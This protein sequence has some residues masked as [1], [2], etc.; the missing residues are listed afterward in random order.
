M[1]LDKE[2]LEEID[3]ICQSLFWIRKKFRV[4]K[5]QK[6]IWL[7]NILLNFP[8]SITVENA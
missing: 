4:S 7:Y 6:S 5:T 8:T 1:K 3:K 2:I